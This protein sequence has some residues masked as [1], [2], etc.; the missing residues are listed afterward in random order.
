MSAS[1]LRVD[2][3]REQ[4]FSLSPATKSILG[5]LESVIASREGTDP[6][7]SYT[8]ELLS[9]GPVAPARKVGEEALEVTIAAISESD[10]RLT[11]ESA[12]L[13]YHLLVLLKSR[14][15]SL[16]DIVRLLEKRHTTAN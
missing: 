15:L 11:E 2:A 12:D 9:G 8:S 10:E 4:L 1:S 6:E 3:T 16:A 7:T 14:G 13:V 5:E